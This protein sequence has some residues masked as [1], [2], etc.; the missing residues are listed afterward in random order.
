MFSLV[1]VSE[2][3]EKSDKTENNK[4]KEYRL[5]SFSS[6]SPSLLDRS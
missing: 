2:N 6:Q 3:M 1:N 4:L 5:L